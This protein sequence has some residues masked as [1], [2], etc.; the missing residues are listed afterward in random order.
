MIATLLQHLWQRDIHGELP[1]TGGGGRQPAIRSLSF[2]YPGRG[3]GRFRATKALNRCYCAEYLSL[4]VHHCTVVAPVMSSRT[5][6]RWS[7]R[8]ISQVFVEPEYNLSF[9]W[10]N[11]I[12]TFS[13]PANS[14]ELILLRLLE[15]FSA[16]IVQWQFSRIHLNRPTDP[17]VSIWMPWSDSLTGILQ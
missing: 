13:D 15:K 6:C 3:L 2:I 17:P 16:C 11:W 7:N 5:Y 12:D 9:D 1:R 8:G 10:R 4:S 14:P